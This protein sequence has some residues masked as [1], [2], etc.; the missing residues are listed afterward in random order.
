M[1]KERKENRW[2]LVIEKYPS[3]IKSPKFK[4]K[5][6]LMNHR[7]DNNKLYKDYEKRIK[8]KLIP[9]KRRLTIPKPLTNEEKEDLNKLS[10]FLNN[11]LKEV[12]N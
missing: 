5:K 7:K 2:F 1:K 12:N 3:L 9:I 11:I 6:D 8:G 4:T 10:G